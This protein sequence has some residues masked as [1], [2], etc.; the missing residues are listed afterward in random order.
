MQAKILNVEPA[1]IPTSIGNLLNCGITSLSGPTGYTQTQP[2]LLLKH[3][4]I[5]NSTGSAITA[6]LY[7]GLTAGDSAGTEFAFAGYSFAANSATDWYGSA[8]FDSADFL[9]GVAAST[10]LTIEIDAEISLA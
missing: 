4:R 3:I 5:T 6:T 2:F 1:Q 10:G 7:K 8:R 9:T